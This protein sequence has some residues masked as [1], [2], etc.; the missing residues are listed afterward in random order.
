MGVGYRE[1]CVFDE[2][3]FYVYVICSGVEID[4]FRGC[5]GVVAGG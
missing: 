2:R 1:L 3:L 4:G 5:S